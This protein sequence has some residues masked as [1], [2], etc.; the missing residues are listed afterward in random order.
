MLVDILKMPSMLT[1][2][3]LF[4]SILS[5]VLIIIAIIKG[6]WQGISSA[7]VKIIINNKIFVIVYLVMILTIIMFFDRDISA[8]CRINYNIYWYTLLDFFC[9]MGETWFVVGIFI[10]IMLIARLVNANYVSK[11]CELSFSIAIYSGLF[12]AIFKFIFNRERPS[13][14]DNPLHFFRFL[15]SNQHKLVD[16]T[17]AYNSMPS[18]HT[19]T[20]VSSLTLIFFAFQNKLIRL[21][22]LFFILIIPFARVYT[23]NHWFSDVF[24]SFVLG[25]LFAYIVYKIHLKK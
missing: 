16:L 17:Y 13:I 14:G 3:G 9:S 10:T 2:L 4:Y 5:I 25:I 22:C 20:V 7:F 21:I 8:W 11:V 15:T 19:I 18:G 23:L 1:T 6:Y 12:N 24:V